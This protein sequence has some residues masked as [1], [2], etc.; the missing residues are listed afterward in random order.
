[1]VPPIKKLLKVSLLAGFCFLYSKLK[2]KFL[3][4]IIHKIITNS[5]I[6]LI[7]FVQWLS[8]RPDII[9]RNLYELFSEYKDKYPAH[10]ITYTEKTIETIFGQKI[11]QVFDDF[12]PT[13]IAS[14]SIAQVYKGRYGNRDVAIKVK[15][16]Y[17]ESNIKNYK[18]V[19]RTAFNLLERFAGIRMLIDLDDFQKSITDQADMFAEGENAEKFAKFY[20]GTLVIIPKVF[21]K[22]KDLIIYS[23]EGG[24]KFE[25]YCKRT[26]YDEQRS[27]ARKFM[28]VCYYPIFCHNM[29]H[30]DIHDANWAINENGQIVLYDFGFVKSIDGDMIS[31]LLT[32]VGTLD[33]FGLLYLMIEAKDMNSNLIKV[34]KYKVSDLD[35]KETCDQNLKNISVI[36]DI[37]YDLHLNIDP[38]ILSYV[39][40]SVI[41]DHLSI[42]YKLD[43]MSDDNLKLDLFNNL[44]KG[45]EDANIDEELV[46]S[47]YEKINHI[48]KYVYI[49]KKQQELFDKIR[50]QGLVVNKDMGKICLSIT[51]LIIVYGRLNATDII[52]IVNY[53]SKNIT[54][55]EYLNR[56][57]R[58]NDLFNRLEN[59][60]YFL[61]KLQR[62]ILDKTKNYDISIDDHEESFN[63]NIDEVLELFHDE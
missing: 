7:K 34:K 37:F 18:E 22:H 6:T 40:N 5:D 38:S 54:K 23:Y 56:V 12:N 21:F 28:A 32:L 31:K 55:P 48:E 10:S 60:L 15:H 49:K 11:Y 4:K 45:T 19:L 2:S 41:L 24:D 9:N 46:D 47:Y 63:K 59:N 53:L 25:D 36:L 3:K 8:M 1:M 13:P 26:S 17:V 52:D 39:I 61:L 35:L 50:E 16:P 14:A 30:A 33:I 42:R 29:F 27:M 51:N 62:F 58:I 44:I 43:K 57:S 20:E